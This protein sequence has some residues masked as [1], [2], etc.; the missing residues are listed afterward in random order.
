MVQKPVFSGVLGINKNFQI[1]QDS[2]SWDIFEI[3]FSPE[4]FKL[5]QKETNRYAKQKINKKT[6]GL[7]IT[8]ICICT[9]EYNLIAR[10]KD[11]FVI[12]IHMSVLCKSSLRD[13]WS[14]CLIIH[15]AY[16]ASVGM[17]RDR[18][19]A[20]LTMFHPNNND[21]KA[22]RGQ[23]GC[24]PLFKIWPVIDTLITKFQDFCTLESS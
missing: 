5:I 22:G 17:S 2:S 1:T 19:H 21:A 8:Q 11:F 6:R 9:V 20:L 7:S 16:T 24:D 15:T 12:I 4:M 18:C 14:L 3:F 23:P 13:Y 10:N